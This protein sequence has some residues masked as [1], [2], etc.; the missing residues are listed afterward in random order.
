M[1]L[2]IVVITLWVISPVLLYLIGALAGKIVEGRLTF[3][4]FPRKQR[5]PAQ[6]A[7]TDGSRAEPWPSP[8][9]PPDP[10]QRQVF[11]LEIILDADHPGVGHCISH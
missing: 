10:A 4:G 8:C 1:S 9:L 5:R 3:I 7:P 2:A 11:D 6:R